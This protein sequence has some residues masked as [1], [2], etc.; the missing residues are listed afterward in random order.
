MGRAQ[1]DTA[2]PP[3]CARLTG[4]SHR[5]GALT[6]RGADPSLCPAPMPQGQAALA[7]AEWGTPPESVPHSPPGF[8]HSFSRL[9]SQAPLCEKA[10]IGGMC[11]GVLGSTISSSLSRPPLIP[12]EDQRTG[13]SLALPRPD[14][15][16]SLL[17]R[18]CGGR[19]IPDGTGIPS[20][21][22]PG[23]SGRPDANV[24][25]VVNFVYWGIL[26]SSHSPS[27]CAK[28]SYVECRRG[29]APCT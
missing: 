29:V 21:A 26:R 15:L 4:F 8:H 5:V 16:S 28:A 22:V 27:R 1:H 6:L 24:H 18:Y 3:R 10:L 23:L 12:L 25:G 20:S 9:L 13:F 19:I 2:H 14:A 7:F 17:L 11:L